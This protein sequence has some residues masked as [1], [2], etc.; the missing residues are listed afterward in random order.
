MDITSHTR[1]N[2]SHK[3]VYAI[4]IFLYDLLIVRLLDSAVDNIL[5][6]LRKE[7]VD[8]LRL[9]RTAGTHPGVADAVPGGARHRAPT[10]AAMRQLA[11]TSAVVRSRLTLRHCAD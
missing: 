9:G 6:K 2:H 8:F 7:G 11:A 3:L 10:V 1:L 4:L 5:L